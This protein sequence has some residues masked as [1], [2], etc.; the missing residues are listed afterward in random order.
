MGY[1][2]VTAELTAKYA[3]RAS[4]RGFFPFGQP[5]IQPAASTLGSQSAPSRTLDFGVRFGVPSIGRFA[6]RIIRFQRRTQ[7]A[8]NHRQ[9][10]SQPR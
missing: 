9:R 7:G 5:R 8:P 4:S 3:T 10:A 1:P 6:H 2:R